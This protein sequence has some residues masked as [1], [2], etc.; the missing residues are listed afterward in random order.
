MGYFLALLGK[1]ASLVLNFTV[2]VEL[3]KRPKLQK[4]KTA[5]LP[6]E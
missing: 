6:V 1:L 3:L 2:K 4:D 5:D